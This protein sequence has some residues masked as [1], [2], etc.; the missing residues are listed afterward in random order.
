MSE[1]QDIFVD[2]SSIGHFEHAFDHVDFNREKMADIFRSH[3]QKNSTLC[4]PNYGF[5]IRKAHVPHLADALSASF[6]EAIN[7]CQSDIYG[8]GK[9]QFFQMKQ[10]SEDCPY[11]PPIGE[12]F[13][14]PMYDAKFVHPLGRFNQTFKLFKGMYLDIDAINLCK[15]QVGRSRGPY[16]CKIEFPVDTIATENLTLALDPLKN[17]KA[18]GDMNIPVLFVLGVQNYDKFDGKPLKNKERQVKL[19]DGFHVY[20]LRIDKIK[21]E[22]ETMLENFLPLGEELTVVYLFND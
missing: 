6:D 13:H 4:D 15:K 7:M 20:M 12:D 9:T 8:F 19:P 18:S 5:R 14:N 2:D 17:K 3:L 1:D 10:Y 22:K 21:V 16:P 11:C